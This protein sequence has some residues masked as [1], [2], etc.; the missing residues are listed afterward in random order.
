M[1]T[2][3]ADLYARLKKFDEQYIPFPPF[4]A[5]KNAIETNLKIFRET[6]LAKHMLV[7]GEAGTGKSS[8]CRWLA[9]Q[10]PKRRLLDRDRIE[11]LVAAIPPA[12]TVPGVIDVMLNSL[13]DP[14]HARGTITLKTARIVSLC[15]ACNVEVMLF[16]EAQHL[17]DRGNT[18]THYMV[19]DWLKYLIDEL[20]V[21]TVLLGLPRV[22]QLLQV[23]DQL[24]RRFS[25]RL[26]LALG[27]SDT[28][29]IETECLQLFLSLVSLMGIPVSS[30][31]FNA[32]EMGQR[33]YF[34]SDGRVA[35][36]KKLLFSALRQALEQDIDVIDAAV[37][38]KA[39]TDEIWWEGIGKLNP[40]S[41]QFEY[42]RLDRGG[43]PFQPA[44]TISRRKSA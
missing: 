29:T 33:L 15:R 44:H 26:R 16:D 8:L 39:F 43:E 41:P 10:H 5:A 18:I 32:Q 24:R 3:T 38:E 37:L 1:T 13:G 20:E 12:A 21:P 7:I 17:Y 40:F 27:Q 36:I 25:S 6:G 34:S 9:L 31:P 22:E 23:N 30:E 2:T 14:W 42:R 11:A 19:G 4:V 28:D 35:Y